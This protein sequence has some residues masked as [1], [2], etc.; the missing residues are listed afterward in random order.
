MGPHAQVIDL[1]GRAVTTGFIDTHA[2]VLVGFTD[3]LYKADLTSAVSIAE[4]LSKIKEQASK[5]APGEWVEGFGWNEGIIAEHRAPTLA[6]LD[7]VTA[8]HP[9]L[10]ENVSHHYGMFSQML[11]AL[12]GFVPKTLRKWRL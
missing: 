6:E 3:M 9:T 11:R 7:A 2:H 4:I 12:S 8:G 10:L 1:T 5:T